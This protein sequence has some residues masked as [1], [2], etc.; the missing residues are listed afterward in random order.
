MATR[1][2]EN[3]KLPML[4]GVERITKAFPTSI[5]GGRSCR[6][7]KLKELLAMVDRPDIGRPDVFITKTCHEG[8]DDMKAL[9]VFL[10]C[11]ANRVA[12]EWPKYQVE[13]TRHWRRN[14]IEWLARCVQQY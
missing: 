1:P 11:P 7:L 10:D 12:T 9:L 6:V 4:L 3:G 13:V 14:V 8:S 2:G 5:A